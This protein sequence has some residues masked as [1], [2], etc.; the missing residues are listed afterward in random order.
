M[1]KLRLIFFLIYLV[2][3]CK[4][5]SAQAPNWLWVKNA[6]GNGFDYG[7][8]ITTDALGNIYVVGKSSSTSITFGSTTFTS[9]VPSAYLVKYDPSGN[10]IWVKHVGP[11]GASNGTSVATDT[12]NNV[13]MTGDFYPPSIVF[14]N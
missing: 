8:D 5:S 13:F 2:F 1:K 9:T 10:I 3:N 7:R 11:P 12:N 14:G 4:Y 6:A